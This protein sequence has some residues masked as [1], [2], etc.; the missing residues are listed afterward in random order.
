MR[1]RETDRQRQKDRETMRKSE[2]GSE[3]ETEMERDSDE[4]LTCGI[5]LLTELAAK[6]HTLTTNMTL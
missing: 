2:K 6:P 1:Q 3:T 5:P 4:N